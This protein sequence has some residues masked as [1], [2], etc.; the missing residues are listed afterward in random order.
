MQGE[1][2]VIEHICADE[3]ERQ[4]GFIHA[5]LEIMILFEAIQAN[6]VINANAAALKW[7]RSRRYILQAAVTTSLM[8]YNRNDKET[9]E[10]PKSAQKRHF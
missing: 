3:S 5:I 7:R 8:Q 10:S 4:F 1:C 9:W 2:A 6:D